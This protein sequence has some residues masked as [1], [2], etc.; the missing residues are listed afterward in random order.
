MVPPAV[1]RV[2]YVGESGEIVDLAPE[3]AERVLGRDP[4]LRR[5][6]EEWY[7][8]SGGRGGRS[9]SSTEIG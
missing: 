7:A 2:A 1:K 3:E 6:W 5:K 4:E 8:K 9:S